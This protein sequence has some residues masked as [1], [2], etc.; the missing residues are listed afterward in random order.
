[1]VVTMFFGML[2]GM[3]VVLLPIQILMVN[4]VTDGIPA[5]A[6]SFDPPQDDVMSELPR[7]RSESVFSNG[8]AMKIITRGFLIGL[9]VLGAFTTVLRFTQSVDSARTAAF[10][11]LVFTQLIHV[12]ECKSEN[13]SLFKIRLFNNMKLVWAVL[14]SAIIVLSTVYI[15]AL[16]PIF[17]TVPLDLKSVLMT[18]GFCFVVPVVSGIFGFFKTRSK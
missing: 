9:S 5:I 13:R 10:F 14:S 8:L 6:L 3:P 17:K 18:L 1:E 2:M 4:L 12:F 7:K 11:A 16:N 15:P